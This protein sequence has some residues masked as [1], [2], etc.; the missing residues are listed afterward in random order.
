MQAEKDL[1]SGLGDAPIII[2]PH[3]LHPFVKDNL[4]YF[5]SKAGIDVG[6][7]T[8]PDQIIVENQT[9]T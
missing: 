8:I 2:I 9:L 3:N 7:S 5:L 4:V 6:D 1:P